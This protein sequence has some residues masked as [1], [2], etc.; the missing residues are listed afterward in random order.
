MRDRDRLAV[1]QPETQ[2]GPNEDFERYPRHEARDFA[3]LEQHGV[4]IVLAPPVEE[5]YGPGHASHP[6]ASAA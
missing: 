4:D 1:R 3:L 6:F 5:V 2:F